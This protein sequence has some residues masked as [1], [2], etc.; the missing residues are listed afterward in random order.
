M[1]NT[2]LDRLFNSD[3]VAPHQDTATLDA[4]LDEASQ[5]V[6]DFSFQDLSEGAKSALLGRVSPTIEKVEYSDDLERPE[7]KPITEED[8]KEAAAQNVEG[9]VTHKRTRRK[10]TTIMP[11]QQN[12]Q[13][14]SIINCLAV[15]LLQDLKKERYQFRE[16]SAH[17]TEYLVNYIL[18][19]V[20][21]EM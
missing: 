4:Q 15:S 10:A 8:I 3:T 6:D 5:D 1:S 12:E 19:K 2:A 11:N 21:G 16:L 7:E 13:V 17:D 18:S 14:G 20:E 9:R